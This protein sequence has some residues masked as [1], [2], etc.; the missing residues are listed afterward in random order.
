MAGSENQNKCP[1]CNGTVVP[2]AQQAEWGRGVVHFNCPRCGQ[3][4]CAEEAYQFREYLPTLADVD[5]FRL[6]GVI[7][8]QFEK[9]SIDRSIERPLILPKNISTFLENAPKS[10]DIA[11]KVRKLLTAIQR[12]TKHAGE[13]IDC[14]KDRSHPLAYAANQDEF[15]YLCGYAY[16]QSWLDID[17][18][19]RDDSLQLRLMPLGWE[20]LQ[21]RPRIES[22]QGFVAMWF[23]PSMTEAFE[24]GLRAAIEADC[25]YRCRRIDTKEYN[26]DVVDE[27]MAEI[28]E[29]RFAV[30]DLTG[31]RNGVYFEA[32]FAMGLDIP[33]IWTCRDNDAGGTHFDAEHFNQIRWKDPADLREKLANRI[34][35]TIGLGPLLPVAEK[36]S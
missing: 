30:C 36:G 1:I 33:T 35:A 8:E 27:L 2:V 14:P 18:L 20:Q 16:K 10:F 23:D 32:G 4:R 6:S 29:S 13:W 3:F 7:R 15:A 11:T 19:S 25:G 12:R 34:R 31:H 26:G 22:A 17:G 9:A 24:G 5:R 28:R 21:L